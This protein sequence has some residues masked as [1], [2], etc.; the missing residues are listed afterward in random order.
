MEKWKIKKKKKKKEEGGMEKRCK[1]NSWFQK[2]VAR[3]SWISA[4]SLPFPYHRFP[5]IP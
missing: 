2:N 1:E 4:R 3:A 5:T